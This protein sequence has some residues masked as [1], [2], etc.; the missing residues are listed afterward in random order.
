MRQACCSFVGPLSEVVQENLP[1]NSS[2]LLWTVSVWWSAL[3][4]SPAKRRPVRLHRCNSSAGRL[5][6][7]RPHVPSLE[8]R[9]AAGTRSS[10][11]I[12]PESQISAFPEAAVSWVALKIPVVSLIR[13]PPFWCEKKKKKNNFTYW[14]MRSNLRRCS[15]TP[16]EERHR[17]LTPTHWPWPPQD[18]T[19]D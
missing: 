12:V 5:Q 18:Q 10:G 8:S 16:E 4:P 13:L 19:R 17:H 11:G 3:T 15:W 6:P 14:E 9:W 1:N 7:S 2:S